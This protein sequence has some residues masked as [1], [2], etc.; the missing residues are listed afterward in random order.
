MLILTIDG[1]DPAYLEIPGLVNLSELA[2]KGFSRTLLGMMPSVTNVNH[3]SILPGAFPERHGIASNYWF[4]P[5][6]ATGGRIECDEQLTAPTLLARFRLP[7]DRIGEFLV[8]AGPDIAFGFAEKMA[9]L[10][11]P[12]PVRS[13][14]SVYERT[15]PLVAYDSP[16]RPEQCQHSLDVV[17]LRAG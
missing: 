2:R 7:P 5:H 15:V 11:M 8:L 4:D 9:V 10:K 16:R 13:H 17:R 1:C 6:T 14:G 12:S 3:A